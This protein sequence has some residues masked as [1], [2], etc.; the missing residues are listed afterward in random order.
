[1]G[2]EHHR[3]CFEANSSSLRDLYERVF[4][5]LPK[6]EAENN[7]RSK[8]YARHYRLIEK[9]FSSTPDCTDFPDIDEFKDAEPWACEYLELATRMMILLQLARDAGVEIP[10]P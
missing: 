6:I 4:P 2:F 1:M 10:Q 5:A 9:A 7:F 8:S 3:N